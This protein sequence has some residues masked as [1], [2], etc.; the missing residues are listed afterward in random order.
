MN[1]KKKIAALSIATGLLSLVGCSSAEN[2]SSNAESV[3]VTAAEK[4]NVSQNDLGALNPSEALEYMKNTADL[5][6]VDVAAK[7]WFDKEH[8]VGAINI[9]IEEIS[10]GEADELYKKIPSGKPVI[11][12][13]RRGMIVPSAYRRVKELRADIP[14]IS[15]IDG[16]PPFAE[17]ND[18]K[19]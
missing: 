2:P 19:K 13:C 4:S 7:R 10:S 12:H 9:P 11:L 17:Y 1:N 15:Y 5:I 18:W 8:F 6:I 3:V 14:E 16:V